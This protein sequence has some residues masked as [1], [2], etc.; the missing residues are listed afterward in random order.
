MYP[1]ILVFVTQEIKTYIILKK[2]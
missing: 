1:L 2:I